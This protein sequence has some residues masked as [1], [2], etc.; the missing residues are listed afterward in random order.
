[1]ESSNYGTEKDFRDYA[2]QPPYFTD[3]EAAFQK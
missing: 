2:F 1:M 3:E